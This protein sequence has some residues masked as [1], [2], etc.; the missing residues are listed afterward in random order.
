MND[1]RME[2]LV[3]DYTRDTID[4]EYDEG[5][6]PRGLACQTRVSKL[7]VRLL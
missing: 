2:Q 6:A 3:K 5:S 1:D 4:T 7:P